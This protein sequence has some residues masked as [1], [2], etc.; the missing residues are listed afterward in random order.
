MP[1]RSG[2]VAA[3]SRSGRA[4]SYA[5]RRCTPRSLA[6]L[7]FAEQ[8]VKR[9]LGAVK[10]GADHQAGDKKS[11]VG[12]E[13]RVTFTDLSGADSDRDIDPSLT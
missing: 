6:A 11:G 4:R 3:R 7:S 13:E 10:T 9:G 12:R 8:L 1:G 2:G 5:D